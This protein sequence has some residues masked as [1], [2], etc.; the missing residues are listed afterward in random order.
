M[1]LRKG[2]LRKP[3]E[4]AGSRVALDRGIK[5]LGVEGL[6]PGTKSYKLARCK[7]LNGL[8]DIFGGGHVK[9]IAPQRS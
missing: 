2:I 7:L 6:E 3:V 1:V 5:L 8:F 9:D 4:P